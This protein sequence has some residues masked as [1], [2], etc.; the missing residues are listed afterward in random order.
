MKR[1]SD[2]VT[3]Y[4]EGG[5]ESAS[6]RSACRQ[7]FA[8]FFAKTELGTTRRPSVVACGSRNAA[9]DAFRTAQKQGRKVLLL[10]DSE[11]PV[12][13]QDHSDEFRPWHHLKQRD[14]WEKPNHA[15]DDDCHLMVQCM[16]AWLISDWSALETFFASGFKTKHKPAAATEALSKTDVYAALERATERCVPKGHYGKGAHSFKLLGLISPK[17]VFAASPWA[18]RFLNELKA[19]KP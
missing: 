9:F 13:K 7:A 18:L 1:I 12:A 4:V 15:Q 14:G 8:E 10:V 16:E 2:D 17:L 3:V 6:L 5:G 19:R 11:G